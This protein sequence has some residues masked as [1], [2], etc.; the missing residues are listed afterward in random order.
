MV[1]ICKYSKVFIQ[2]FVLKEEKDHLKELS[3]LFVTS[4]YSAYE[5]GLKNRAALK[6]HRIAFDKKTD[7]E[8]NEL[9]S[10]CCYV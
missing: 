6:G 10:C 1:E 9:L 7:P 4:S 8:H 3:F 5:S 2:S